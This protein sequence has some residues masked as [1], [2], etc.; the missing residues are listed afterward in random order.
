AVF[1][2]GSTGSAFLLNHTVGEG[3]IYNTGFVLPASKM[4]DFI[5]RFGME[6]EEGEPNRARNRRMVEAYL[7]IGVAELDA[8]LTVLW[9]SDPDHTA[10]EYGMASRRTVEALRLND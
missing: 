7:E 2:S 10:H 6:P 5:A 3:A 1:S 8:P 9:I 4:E